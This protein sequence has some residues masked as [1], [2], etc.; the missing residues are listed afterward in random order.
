M[1]KKRFNYPLMNHCIIA[2]TIITT[3]KLTQPPTT[4]TTFPAPFTGAIFPTTAVPR[5]PAESVQLISAQ[6]NPSGQ[7]PP[8]ALAAQPVQPAAH[9]R[10]SPPGEDRD[11][12][13]SIPIT[14]V[15]PLSSTIVVEEIGGQEV[16]FTSRPVRQQPP[17]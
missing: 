16:G 17:W 12:V 8:P 11:T 6:A 4:T 7:Q 13:G 2:I 1:A 9:L 15:A 5:P 3:V 10:P 14:I